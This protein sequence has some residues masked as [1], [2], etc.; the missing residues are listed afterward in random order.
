MTRA[1][2]AWSGAIP[3]TWLMIIIC[4]NFTVT[5]HNPILTHGTRRSSQTLVQR[6]PG[7]IALAENI[8]AIGMVPRTCLA[9]LFRPGACHCFTSDTVCA[10]YRQDSR[11]VSHVTNIASLA[12]G[13]EGPQLLLRGGRIPVTHVGLG[14]VRKAGPKSLFSGNLA[15]SGV[16]NETLI[17]LTRT[18]EYHLQSS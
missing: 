10:A 4:L 11:L 8:S 18:G 6:F 13:S 12:L 15:F 9:C 7:N 14:A 1:M 17:T 16:S 5:D 2:R 3:S